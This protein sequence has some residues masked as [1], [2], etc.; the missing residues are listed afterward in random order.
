MDKRI[1]S[2]T[3]PSP[4]PVSHGN[5]KD[6]ETGLEPADPQS[7]VIYSIYDRNISIED[8]RVAIFVN[9]IGA[10]IL[11][12]PLEHGKHVAGCESDRCRLQTR[13]GGN[14]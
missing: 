9:P 14:G 3:S 2:I 4:Q 11:D 8:A 6:C 5:D 13:E 10:E 12:K 7:P 1:S